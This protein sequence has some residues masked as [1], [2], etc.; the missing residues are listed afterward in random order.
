MP[1]RAFTL[2][3]ALS[4]A[5]LDDLYVASQ[6]R[7]RIE[8]P[9]ARAPVHFP[10]AEVAPHQSRRYRRADRIEERSSERRSSLRS[11]KTWD[12]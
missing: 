12:A 2:D 7:S 4:P 8:D 9:E 10:D 5:D 6:D 11:R 3:R 1:L